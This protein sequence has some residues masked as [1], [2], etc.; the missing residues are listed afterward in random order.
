M[1][2][3]LQLC[4]RAILLHQGQVLM[5]GPAAEVMKSYVA[6]PETG[7][8]VDLWS[9]P[10]RDPSLS[11]ALQSITLCDSAD[12]PTVMFAP[13]DIV[14]L[15]IS[16]KLNRRI[17]NPLVASAFHNWRGERLFAVA[18]YMSPFPVEQIEGQCLI[19]CRFE[20]PN[21]VPGKYVF[22]IALNESPDRY[23]DHISDVAAFTIAPSDYLGAT[24]PLSSNF[25]SVMVRSEWEAF[26]EQPRAEEV[27]IRSAN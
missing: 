6:E 1:N 9:H 11:P 2:A 24:H 3:V 12:N 20:L 14:Q 23:T 18:T 4:E 19:I 7:S 16:L 26:N 21:L 10:N 15:K 27:G 25:G 22:D 13:G 8:T 17:I 5:D